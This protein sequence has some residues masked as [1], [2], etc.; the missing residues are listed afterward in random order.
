MKNLKY[1]LKK[2]AKAFDNI[3]GARL[4]KGF[5]PDIRISKNYTLAF[6]IKN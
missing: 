6:V 5:I 1:I 4:K 3:V 2:E